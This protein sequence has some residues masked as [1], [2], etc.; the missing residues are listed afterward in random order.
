MVVP[1]ESASEKFAV[2]AIPRHPDDIAVAAINSRAPRPAKY[3]RRKCHA[4]DTAIAD[5]KK[6]FA[7]Q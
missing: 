6:A 4:A 2:K 3:S 7:I 1:P 5:I